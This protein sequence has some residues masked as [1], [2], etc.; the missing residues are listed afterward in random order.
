MCYFIDDERP[1]SI[2]IL[3]DYS[4]TTFIATISGTVHLPKITLHFING[5]ASLGGASMW[6][7]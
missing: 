5:S 2:H 3:H 1:P 7:R 6:T 4:P